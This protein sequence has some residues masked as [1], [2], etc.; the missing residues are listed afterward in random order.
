MGGG[1]PESP[2]ILDADVLID[3]CQS[4]ISVLSI[5]SSHLGPIHLATP[6]LDE[7]RA[8]NERMCARLGIELVEPEIQHVILAAE[9]R[10][11]LSFEDKLCLFLAKDNNWICVTNEKL[12]Q[13]ECRKEE[14]KTVWGLELL[15]VL[16]EVGGIT[17]KRAS[18]I[19]ASIHEQN[20]L[21]INKQVVQRFLERIGHESRD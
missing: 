17:K 11:S 4:D 15:A 2:L 12:L 16:V 10:G 9:E 18:H 6:V 21:Y 20:P 5:I 1:R 7:V 3:F 8:L 14:V 19:A 13:R